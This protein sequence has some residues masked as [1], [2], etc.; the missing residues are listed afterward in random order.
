V[1]FDRDP[2]FIRPNNNRGLAKSKPSL[3]TTRTYHSQWS[4][5]RLL[6]LYKTWTKVSQH[7]ATESVIDVVVRS[8]DLTR[9]E[10]IRIEN[11]VKR[12]SASDPSF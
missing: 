1:R 3:P 11:H 5:C 10:D 9:L 7:P 4:Y 12:S 2:W 6:G 8:L